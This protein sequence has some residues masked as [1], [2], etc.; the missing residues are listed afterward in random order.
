[1]RKGKI[2]LPNYRTETTWPDLRIVTKS[3][4]KLS[5]LIAFAFLP[6]ARHNKP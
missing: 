6:K 1:M 4:Q 2:Y 3:F 5:E